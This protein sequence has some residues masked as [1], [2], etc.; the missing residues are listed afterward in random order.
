MVKRFLADLYVFQSAL[1]AEAGS[2]SFTITATDTRVSFQSAPPSCEGGDKTR[3]I[4]AGYQLVS[5]RAAPKRGRQPAAGASLESGT[6]FQSAP[7]SC[8]GGDR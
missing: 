1:R 4:S 2:D 5:I 6:K 8:A 3:R 7:P